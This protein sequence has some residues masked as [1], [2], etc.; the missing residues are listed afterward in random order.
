MAFERT[1]FLEFILHLLNC[2]VF[3][4]FFVFV[5]GFPQ[6][7]AQAGRPGYCELCTFTYRDLAE[8]LASDLHRGKATDDANF[9]LIDAVPA[10]H[11]LKL[12]E[13]VRTSFARR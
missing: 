2:D 5:I 9:A 6:M 7:Q 10:Y 4:N 13:Q 3:S 8:H 12:A 11:A 1:I